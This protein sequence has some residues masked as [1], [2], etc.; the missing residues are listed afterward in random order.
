MIDDV[1]LEELYGKWEPKLY[2]AAMA[3]T[4]RHFAALVGGPRWDDPCTIILMRDTV[5]HTFSRSD[6]RRELREIR[7]V[8]SSKDSEGPS[9]VTISLQG[10]IYV[11]GPDGSQHLIIPGTQA[12][13]E[14][15][16][17][18]DFRSIL[19]YDD[20]WL[21]A[22]SG[23]FL[24]LG[25]SASRRTCHHRLK[26]NTLTPRLNGPFSARTLKV[27][28]L[29]LRSKDRTNDTSTFTQVT[30]CIEV[31]CRTTVSANFFAPF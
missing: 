22:G 16:A 1:G 25:R 9:Y 13:T 6:V 29:S 21:I 8:P 17:E 28:S 10:D 2:H 27:K 11:V 23:N 19:P 5:E 30:H 24:K 7:V 26:L 18:V 31:A 14:T 15:A 12:E 3:H 4:D 20:R